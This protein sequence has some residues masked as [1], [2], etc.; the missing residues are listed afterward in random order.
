ML[1]RGWGGLVVMDWKTPSAIVERPVGVREGREGKRVDGLQMFPRQTNR[2]ETGLGDLESLIV[3]FWDMSRPVACLVGG[4]LLSMLEPGGATSD[5]RGSGDGGVS[6]GL[7]PSGKAIP[8][9]KPGH[10]HSQ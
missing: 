5:L 3:L 8:H 7:A 1:I 4:R 10:F 2:T 6:S 9:S